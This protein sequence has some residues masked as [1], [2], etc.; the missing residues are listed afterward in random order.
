MLERLNFGQ[1]WKRL[2]VVERSHRGPQ[3]GILGLGLLMFIGIYWMF[4]ATIPAISG[5]VT[6]GNIWGSEDDLLSQPL[7]YASTGGA[8]MLTMG[9]LGVIRFCSYLDYRIRSE[10]WD[11]ELG[12]RRAGRHLQ[13]GRSL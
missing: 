1:A 10:G 3:I 7:L 13:A 2:R 11:I 9:L 12:M 4:F 8:I 6:S 5:V